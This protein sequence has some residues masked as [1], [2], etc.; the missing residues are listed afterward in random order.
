MKC[1]SAIVLPK[2][3]LPTCLIFASALSAQTRPA[4]S[5]G[6]WAVARYGHTAFSPPTEPQDEEDEEGVGRSFLFK[7][8]VLSAFYAY[9][10]IPKLSSI[11]FAG[12]RL[13]LALR[14]PG[15]YVGLD[16]IK[17][18]AS[19]SS[20]NRV[21]P[22]WLPLQAMGLHPRLVYDRV[23]RSP[24]LQ[25]IKFAPQDFWLRFNPGRAD[26]LTLRIGQ[27]VLPYGV[28]P[29]LAPRQQFMLPVEAIDLGLKWDW[30]IALKGPFGEYD[31]E[32]AATIGS[33]VALHDPGYFSNSGRGSYLFTGRFGSPTYWDF[34]NGL[35]FLYGK[36][37]VIMGPTVIS[38][39]AISRWR[40]AYDVFYKY[41]T[42]LMLGGQV[43]YGQNGFAGDA[44]YVTI[45]NGSKP[46]EV[47]GARGWVDWVVPRVQNVRLSF[48]YESVIRDLSTPWS[49]DAAVIFQLQ[50]S[51]T[52]SITAM[53]DYREEL[54]SSMGSESDVLYFTF[55]FYG[56]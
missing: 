48:Q 2:I 32:M 55:I 51:I 10:R 54:Y 9:D 46:S 30:G 27:F 25:P 44:Q 5:S 3:V 47:L 31:W 39:V 11:S 22:G 4:N 7:E 6:D 13:E 14:P 16:Y 52:T 20:V 17:T 33:G 40:I 21:L 50:Y 8:L 43:T 41:G 45:T 19:S 1:F 24:G 36:L 29:I 18:F 37:P 56:D 12:D 23:E 49:E 53:L 35:S 34:Q 42:Y 26:R 38:D 15:N 28:N